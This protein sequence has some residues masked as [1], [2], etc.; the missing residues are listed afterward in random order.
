MEITHEDC[1]LGT[2]EQENAIHKEQETDAIVNSVEPDAV[3]DEIEF[4]ENG[5]KR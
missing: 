4:N 3:H 2:C 1:N 5:T